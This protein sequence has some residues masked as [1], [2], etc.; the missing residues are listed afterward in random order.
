MHRTLSL[1]PLFLLAACT[2]TVA[3]EPITV[4]RITEGELSGDDRKDEDGKIFDTW[5]F[6]ARAGVTYMVTLRSDNF[7]AY[8]LAGPA[9]G[10]AC[11]PCKENDDAVGNA[12]RVVLE[13]EAGGAR[14]VRVTTWEAGESGRYTLAVDE[15]EA[16]PPPGAG[17]PPAGQGGSVLQ[18]GAP[19]TGV[20]ENGDRRAPYTQLQ[21]SL[22]D[23]WTYRGS[24]GESLTVS[25][26]S[27][28]FDPFLRVYRWDGGRWRLLASNDD[29]RL[30]GTASEVVVGLPA[31]GEY[32]VH[33]AAFQESAAGAYTLAASSTPGAAAGV[34]ATGELPVLTPGGSVAAE[35]AAGDPVA[36]DGTFFDAYRYS[37][38]AGETAT[39]E[40]LSETFA[41]VL[42]IGVRE[43]GAWREVARGDNG[44]QGLLTAVTMRFPARAEYE[45][46]V[47]TS[48]AGGTGAYSLFS[49]TNVDDDTAAGSRDT[50]ITPGQTREGRLEAGDRHGYTG[51][52]EDAWEMT[53]DGQVTIDLRSSDFDSLL[54]FFGELPDGTWNELARNDNSGGGTD[55][56]LV[57]QL[58]SGRRYRIH[59]TTYDAE[60]TGQYRLTVSR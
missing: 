6:N 49:V 25:L 14:V 44:G 21:N 18:P 3:Q 7:D 57:A 37:A 56:R 26:S 5:R 2:P 52:F 4:G 59:V 43:N 55:S 19:V 46:R 24:A 29:D 42:R 22:Y 23:V 8:L 58:I 33:A 30:G 10:D 41:D 31:D 35:L 47:G 27:D 53:G 12:A 36:E 1:L 48:K 11:A 9:D 38:S 40:L 39:F 45:I 15:V 34:A 50:T 13:E 32:Q 51:A 17:P 54:R 28:D 60:G 16:P 20:L